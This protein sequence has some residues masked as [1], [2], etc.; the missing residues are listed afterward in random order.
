MGGGRG[1]RLGG[2]KSEEGGGGL[3]RLI[4]CLVS[5]QW[6]RPD[7]KATFFCISSV[8]RVF[9]SIDTLVERCFAEGSGHDSRI[10]S[11]DR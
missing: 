7:S 4:L 1:G 5:G 3:G 9:P 2:E 11:I 6:A 8:K 10:A